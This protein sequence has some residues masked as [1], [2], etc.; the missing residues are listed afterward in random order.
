MRSGAD[1]ECKEIF[2]AKRSDQLDEAADGTG[3][4]GSGVSHQRLGRGWY[5]DRV[6][7]VPKCIRA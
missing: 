1:N 2:D 7:A 6:V 4:D 5:R 3:R